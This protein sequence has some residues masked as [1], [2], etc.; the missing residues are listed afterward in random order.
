MVFRYHAMVSRHTICYLMAFF[1]FCFCSGLQIFARSWT[2]RTPS[3]LNRP[4]F[5]VMMMICCVT[6]K[7]SKQ[8]SL[9]FCLNMDFWPNEYQMQNDKNQTKQTEKKQLFKQSLYVA[10]HFKHKCWMKMN[11]KIKEKQRRWWRRRR[12]PKKTWAS[13]D[14]DVTINNQ[15]TFWLILL[16]WVSFSLSLFFLAKINWFGWWFQGIM[17]NNLNTFQH[18]ASMNAITISYNQ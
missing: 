2:M 15:L 1:R 8:C 10:N 9:I 17:L 13:D 5:K 12:R 16:R 18:H 3:R 11:G 4:C 6:G 7:R 14:N